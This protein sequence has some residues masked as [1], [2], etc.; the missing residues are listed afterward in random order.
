MWTLAPASDLIYVFRSLLFYRDIE[1]L[2][3]SYAWGQCWSGS[4]PGT[5][6][7]RRGRECPPGDRRWLRVIIYQFVDQCIIRQR[8]RF[9]FNHH[10]C[11]WIVERGP[12]ELGTGCHSH[13]VIITVVNDII[14]WH[15]YFLVTGTVQHFVLIFILV[16][17]FVLEDEVTN[18]AV[19]T[20][21]ADNPQT[22]SNATRLGRFPAIET[23]L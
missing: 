23:H 7:G 8:I 13:F 6:P 1:D 14:H 18:I 11:L 22:D 21:H 4:T 9:N 19:L 5:Q 2:T 20:F 17:L 10:Q 12:G 16:W 15:K 3:R